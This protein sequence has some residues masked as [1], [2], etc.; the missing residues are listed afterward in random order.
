MRTLKNA[1]QIW[2][3]FEDYLAPLLGMKP[4][5]RALYSY[6]VR[7]S[8]LEGRRGVVLGMPQLG[9]GA[10]LGYAPARFH[11]FR[12]VRKR[13]VEVKPYRKKSYAIR[14]FLPEEVLRELRPRDFAAVSLELR[15]VSKDRVLRAKILRRERGRCFYCNQ[16]LVEGRIWFDHIVALARGGNPEEKNVV[17][18][19]MPCNQSKSTRSGEEFLRQ[20]CKEGTISK[21]RLKKQRTAMR[22]ILRGKVRLAKVA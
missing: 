15:R 4:G 7:H 13:C 9:R 18:C 21:E 8:R 12:L 17:A 2:K 1:G 20:L 16:V 14:V 22:E 10:G 11:L 5:E 19:C 6:L 3:E